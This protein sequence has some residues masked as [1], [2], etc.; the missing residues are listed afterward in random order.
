[1]ASASLAGSGIGTASGFVESGIWPCPSDSA[2]SLDFD[3]LAAAALLPWSLSSSAER[4]AALFFPPSL[5]S[6]TAAGFFFLL[7]AIDIAYLIQ[8]GT[9]AMA[10]EMHSATLFKNLAVRS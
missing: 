6:A 9:Q 4:L 5:P 2:A 10:G 3:H 1:V 8:S 7:S